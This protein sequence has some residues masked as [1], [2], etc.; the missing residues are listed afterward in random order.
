MILAAQHFVNEYHNQTTVH[1]LGLLVVLVLG[2]ATLCVDR[3][4]A[5]WPMIIMA[6]FVSSAQRIV[7][8]TL[9]FD[10]IRLMVLFGHI[11]VI[12]KREW[13]DFNWQKIDSCVIV[14]ALGHL[15]M[16][17]LR[18]GPA[19]FVNKLGM[20]YDVIGLYFFFR[21]MIR[22][23]DDIKMLALG[24]SLIATPV[25]LAFC[26]EFSTGRNMFSVFGGVSA[27][28]GIRDGRLR[29]QGAFAHP[30]LA[31]TF[32]VSLIPLMAIQWIERRG[33]KKM[34][35]I[36]TFSALGIVIACNSA[37]PVTGVMFA[38]VG[39]LSFFVR[40]WMRE[41]RWGLVVLL[42][43]LH[44]V[45]N[46]PVWH[47]ISR[48]SIVGGNSGYHRYQL[49][50]GAINHFHEWWIVGSTKGTEHWGHHTFDVT[51]TYIVQGLHGG[52]LLL[53]IF[54][55]LIVLGFILIGRAV[56][57]DRRNLNN[58]LWYW[59]LGVTLFVHA[60]GF[61]S[62]A[63]FG[64]TRIVWYLTIAMIASAAGKRADQSQYSSVPRVKIMHKPV[65]DNLVS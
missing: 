31:G 14:F 40:H 30:I 42:V 54:I 9:D 8:G 53:G 20:A 27:V 39:F 34:A 49:I 22:G 19:I 32:W 59:A 63:Y 41:V 26:L 36:G 12:S 43:G 23:L 52:I 25:F 13:L 57:V 28:T 61:L 44:L 2:F 58:V 10:F 17:V 60:T 29:C 3:R 5:V 56:Q 65:I 33:R 62:I 64:Q 1:P 15:L 4:Y 7:V 51:N 6:C 46:A 18:V 11:R 21:M 48:I 35:V 16:G 50:D 47:L 38:V 45:M 55:A 24:F 37:T